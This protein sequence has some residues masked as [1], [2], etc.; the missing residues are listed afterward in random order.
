MATKSEQSISTE[1]LRS[2]AMQSGTE[3]HVKVDQRKLIDKILARYS[4]DFVV[5]RELIQN[6]DDVRATSFQLSISC[7]RPDSKSTGHFHGCAIT[8][9]RASNNGQPFTEVDWE[10]VAAI[11]DGNIDVNSV[12]QFGVGFFS[13]FSYSDEPIIISGKE[14]LV[15]AWRDDKTLTTYRQKLR[16]D[17]RSQWT[18]MR[19]SMR[20][21]FILLTNPSATN[22]SGTKDG[23][24]P[25]DEIIPTIDLQQLKTFFTRGRTF[26]LVESIRLPFV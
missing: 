15:F 4:S 8:E 22:L 25:S 5:F 2:G 17:Q 24:T 14:Y 26:A 13:V 1:S 11:A 21:P 16:A 19:M 23:S 7:R 18:T 3:G 12:G 20:H 6:A 9:L 10:R